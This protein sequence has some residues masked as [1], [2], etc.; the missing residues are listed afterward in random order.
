MKKAVDRVFG[1]DAPGPRLT[2]L[3][4]ALLALAVAVPV[5]GLIGLV[6]WLL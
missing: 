4:A 2:T 5:G 6:D 3:G 1:H